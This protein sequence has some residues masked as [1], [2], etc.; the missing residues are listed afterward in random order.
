LFLPM[1]PPPLSFTHTH[2]RFARRYFSPQVFR[3]AN[4]AGFAS[5]TAEIIDTVR[6]RNIN[7]ITELYAGVGCI[8]LTV[9]TE[10]SDQLEYVRCSDENVNNKRS[11]ELSVASMEGKGLEKKLSYRSMAAGDALKAGEGDGC[12]CLIVDPPRAGLS[13]DVCEHLV[14]GGLKE[15]K[16]LIYV[17]CGFDALARDL[18]VLLKGE[19]GWTIDSAKGFLLFPGSNHVETLVVL[20]RK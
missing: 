2:A 10:L 3:Q 19:S 8:G 15:C 7:K 6:D 4:L 17:S 14:G 1:T 12:E 11:F 18:E 16:T 5:I 20:S 9:F 13:A